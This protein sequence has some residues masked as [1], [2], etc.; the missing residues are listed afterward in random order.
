MSSYIDLA[1]PFADPAAADP[2]AELVSAGRYRLPDLTIGPDGELIT[3]DK[4][5]GGWM[6]A[7]NAAKAISDARALDLWHQRELLRGLAI[8]PELYDL[9][10]GTVS[11]LADSPSELRVALEEVSGRILAAAR[12]D[13]GAAHGTALHMLTDAADRGMPVYGRPDMLERVSDIGALLDAH[14][15]EVIPE[16]IERQVVLLR[17][18]I[19]G[20]LDRILLER[21][22]GFLRLADL[23]TQKAFWGDLE[24]TV[25]LWIYANADAMWDR[26]RLCYVDMPKI[27]Q[28][29]ALVIW[30]PREGRSTPEGVPLP[31]AALKR[32]PLEHGAEAMRV[33]ME[34]Y[35]LRSAAKSKRA[36]WADFRPFPESTMKRTEAYAARLQEAGSLADGSAV[37]AEVRAAGLHLVPELLQAAQDS[38]ERFLLP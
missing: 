27:E 13:A 35:A 32:V 1:D 12:A 28:D 31:G 17:H 33:A 14:E 7:T 22:T 30:Y 19:A 36:P 37:W 20:T 24:V 6:R 3:G 8:R 18:G 15:L 25:Q 34:A 38:A 21:L 4:R 11:S 23:K 9:L 26:E 29:H 5:P 2:G 16:Y 10:C